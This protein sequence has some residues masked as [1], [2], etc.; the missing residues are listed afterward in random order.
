MALV[1]EILTQKTQVFADQK[2]PL[3]EGF[4][5]SIKENAEK[6]ADAIDSYASLV[7]PVSTTN[8][9][10]KKALYDMMN[11]IT[12]PPSE[13]PNP[14]PF[15]I[16]Y[17]S[18]ESRLRAFNTY[19]RDTVG[20]K[21][22]PALDK[23]SIFNILNSI[24]DTYN[25]LKP[26]LAVS[27]NDIKYNQRRFNQIFAKDIENKRQFPLLSDGVTI[28]SKGLP[29]LYKFIPLNKEGVIVALQEDGI[30]GDDTIRYYPIEEFRI[31]EGENAEWER[32]YSK[33][34]F[35]TQPSVNGAV[36]L[37]KP[38]LIKNHYNIQ[39]F[40]QRMEPSFFKKN[41]IDKKLSNDYAKIMI[42]KTQAQTDGNIFD[43]TP[44][45]SK[46]SDFQKTYEL[47][48]ST[49][50]QIWLDNKIKTLSDYSIFL[51]S[52][53]ASF[54]TKPPIQKNAL[55]ALENGITAYATALAIGMNPTFTGA[56]S[57]N[58]ISFQAVIAKGSAG[59]SNKECLDLMVNL[60]NSY[61][62]TG[63]AT[64]NSSGATSTWS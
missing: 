26:I 50:D 18:P 28:N 40:A 44:I 63:I 20:Y 1:K 61:F 9:I 7:I 6:W 41:F 34:D 17:K 39:S 60:I 19:L 21:S 14:F 62:K 5:L 25:K 37:S 33:I 4:P 13:E 31:Y 42:E 2:S 54:T 30:I 38:Q 27:E 49:C 22:N 43:K 15:T 10:A 64:N 45:V 59:G 57:P 8:T 56:P 55:T 16:Y 51:K 46:V 36:A 12:E 48:H 11:N 32:V 35:I 53:K 3:F 47:N 23:S 52:K 58:P 29:Y 24:R